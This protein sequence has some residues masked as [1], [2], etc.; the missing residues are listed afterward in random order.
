MATTVSV[1]WLCECVRYWLYRGDEWFIRKH[2][3]V[4]L[5]TSDAYKCSLLMYSK[6]NCR[7]V[8]EAL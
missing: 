5:I 6:F 4:V 2:V 7:D 8:V 3:T 1:I